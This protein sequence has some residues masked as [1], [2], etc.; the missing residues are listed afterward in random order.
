V[1]M[2]GFRSASLA[3]PVEMAM[4]GFTLGRTRSARSA[5]VLERTEQVGSR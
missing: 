5:S 1:T 2:A 4:Q 3:S